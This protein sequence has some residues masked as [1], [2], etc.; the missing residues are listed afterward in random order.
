MLD[1]ATNLPADE[2]AVYGTAGN[3][4]SLGITTIGTG[5]TNPMTITFPQSIQ[6]FFVTV[7]NGNTIPVSYM[8]ADN[9][10]N[11]ATYLIPSNLSGGGQTIGFAAT[12]TTVTITA[13]TGQSVG[14]GIA[15]DFFVGNVNFNQPLPTGLAPTSTTGTGITPPGS[16]SPAATPAPPSLVL[17]LAGLAAAGICASPGGRRTLLGR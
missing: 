1:G 11:S 2:T 3:A 17:A 10:G 6:N 5:F 16:P 4:A 13:L 14:G 12:G 9:A 7:L 15:W 8:V